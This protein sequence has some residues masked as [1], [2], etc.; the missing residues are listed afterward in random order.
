MLAFSPVRDKSKTIADLASGLEKD[1]LRSLTNEMV[2]RM[3]A[4]IRP[5]TARSVS[6][7]PRSPVPGPRLTDR[8]IHAPASSNTWLA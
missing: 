6:P 2:D 7:L 8:V 4:L 3:L 5:P 1:D